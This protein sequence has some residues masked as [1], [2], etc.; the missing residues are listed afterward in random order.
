MINYFAYGGGLLSG[1]THISNLFP[2]LRC[3][4]NSFSSSL[5]ILLPFFAHSVGT[6]D[7]VLILF[8]TITRRASNVVPGGSTK[9]L[10]S[11]KWYLIIFLPSLMFSL[12]GE[13]A[14]VVGL[15]AGFNE[16]TPG[17]SGDWPREDRLALAFE[18]SEGEP[19]PPPPEE[20]LN[21]GFGRGTEPLE[22]CD[23]D[24]LNMLAVETTEPVDCR[25]VELL[26]SSVVFLTHDGFVE[27]AGSELRV[28]LTELVVVVDGVGDSDFFHGGFVLDIAG[29]SDAAGTLGLA[30]AAGGAGVGAGAG[31]GVKDSLLLSIF[32]LAAMNSSLLR[33]PSWYS[34]AN[35][36]ISSERD[37]PSPLLLLLLLLLLGCGTGAAG[38]SVDDTGVVVVI[39]LC[40]G[41]RSA[42]PGPDDDDGP[43]V[44]LGGG[45]PPPPPIVLLFLSSANNPPPPALPASPAPTTL[46]RGEL[47][48]T[49][50]RE[51]VAG[52]GRGGPLLPPDAA[53]GGGTAGGP[54]PG[55]A[56]TIVGR[57]P[58]LFFLSFLSFLDGGGGRLLC[59][60][61][62]GVADAFPDFKSSVAACIRLAAN[63]LSATCANEPMSLSSSFQEVTTSDFFIL[64][65]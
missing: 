14:A 56:S 51:L 26:E 47:L 36:D 29:L 53:G 24:L 50:V 33:R 2:F 55:L 37:F 9:R 43:Y 1:D 62:T 59:T 21:D 41:G 27:M 44:L 19:N 34:F 31:A 61:A 60:I 13:D 65:F 39:V 40:G 46:F 6:E 12:T 54:P 22:A 4:S 64:I 38:G 58:P 11:L 7:R 57:S 20:P 35:E 10:V 28:V 18:I 5:I 25:I 42:G 45:G 8:R 32:A 16:A 52:G 30:E 15:S 23:D 63:T 3:A 49:E 17:L 48:R